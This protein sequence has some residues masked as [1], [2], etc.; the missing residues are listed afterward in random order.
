MERTFLEFFAGIGLVRVALEQHGWRAVLA[1]DI[2]PGK[3]RMY[4]DNFPDAPDRYMV[5]DI[6]DLGSEDIPTASLAQASFPCVD[7]SL[8]GYRRGLNGHR[9]GAYWGFVKLLKEL[10]DRRPPLLLIENVVG[11]LSSNGGEDFRVAL[12]A[13]SELGYSYDAFV[14]NALRFV[15]QSRPRLFVIGMLGRPYWEATRPGFFPPRAPDLCPTQLRDFIARHSGLNWC[16]L[17]LPPPPAPVADFTPLLE[18]LEEGDERWWPEHRVD[19][20]L[21]QMSQRHRRVADSMINSP[22][23]SCGTVYRR[24][25]YGRSMAELR[26]DGIAGCLRTP[27]GGSSRQIL[28]VAGRGQCRA[29]FMTPR[30]YAR[31]QGVADWYKITAPTNQ[32]LFGFG[33]AVCVP[34]IQWI[35]ENALNRL[36]QRVAVSEPAMLAE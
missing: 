4:A 25:R 23:V 11:F 17:P 9:S 8:A 2:D 32:A 29:R 27:K 16:F 15:P 24:I 7:L 35:A 6:H 10:G 22:S 13:L 1:N 5:A 12:E 30:E 26:T 20:L 21:N 3:Y 31:L 18:E 19:Y 14:L 33:D 28:F 34:A 36:T